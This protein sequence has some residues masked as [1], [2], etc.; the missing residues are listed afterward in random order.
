VW[1]LDQAR[2]QKGKYDET[3]TTRGKAR[4]GAKT[5]TETK[6]AATGAG[7][8]GSATGTET[9]TATRRTATGGAKTGTETETAAT[10]AAASGAA[11]GTETETAARGAKAT[12][13]ATGT[14]TSTA[15]TRAAT[16]ET[17]KVVAS[18]AGRAGAGERQ[19]PLL[20]GGR[21]GCAL[22][23]GESGTGKIRFWS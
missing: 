10:G 1:N 14:E 23:V 15:A 19:R 9:K 7:A 5:G 11:T 21:A 6:T 20:G 8:S 12:G 3:E 13:A 16:E 18:F 2:I 4:S 17:V 22:H